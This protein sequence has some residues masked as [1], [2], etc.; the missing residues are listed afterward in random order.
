MEVCIF[1]K[2]HKMKKSLL[3]HY[4][5]SHEVEYKRCQANKWYCEK[6]NLILFPNKEQKDKHDEKCLFCKSKKINNE[7]SFD[8]ISIYGH[9][10]IE[11]KM[12]KI[13][14]EVKFPVFDFDKYI[15]KDISSINLNDLDS[16]IEQEKNILY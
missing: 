16:F 11:S 12:P 2:N 9:E 14:K 13:K 7:I 6:N 4:L 10:A 8:E 1:D 5:R 15:K 3:M